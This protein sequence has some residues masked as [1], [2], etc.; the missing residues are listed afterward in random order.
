M[1]MPSAVIDMDDSGEAY[2][3]VNDPNGNWSE[4]HAVRDPVAEEEEEKFRR[5][6]KYFFMNPCDKYTARRRKPW[7][8]DPADPEDRCGHH[9]A[10]V[11]W[12]Q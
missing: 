1:P 12:S 10:G 9:S 8:A 7:K 2:L 4:S 11:V 5:K 6:L 3:C